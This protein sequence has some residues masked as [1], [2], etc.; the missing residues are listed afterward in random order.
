MI[1]FS[2]KEIDDTKDLNENV[3]IELAKDGSLV[4]MTIEHAKQLAS[5]IDFPFQ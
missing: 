2:S 3:L 1:H 5:M 4:G